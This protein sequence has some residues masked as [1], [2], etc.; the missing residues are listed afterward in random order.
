MTKHTYDLAV[1]SDLHRDAYGFRPTPEEL[2]A[3]KRLPPDE[4]QALWDSWV[5]AQEWWMD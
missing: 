2:S 3:I 5:E 4:I 1:L